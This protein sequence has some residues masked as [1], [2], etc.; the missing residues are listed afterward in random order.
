MKALNNL[1][2]E[3]S[4]FFENMINQVPTFMAKNGTPIESNQ[5]IRKSSMKNWVNVLFI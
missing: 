4:D 5:K 3:N 1:V 2:H